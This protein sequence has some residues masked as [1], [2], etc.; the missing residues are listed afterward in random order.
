ML[1][2]AYHIIIFDNHKL[3]SSLIFWSAIIMLSCV[4][5]KVTSDHPCYDEEVTTEEETKLSLGGRW[6]KEEMEMSKQNK[7]VLRRKEIIC[8]GIY[9]ANW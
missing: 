4:K 6:A 8:T 7:G 2:Q 9:I 5:P 3:K 1:F